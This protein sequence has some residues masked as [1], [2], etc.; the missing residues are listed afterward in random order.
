MDFE[1][2][3]FD[4]DGLLLKT[5]AIAIKAFEEACEDLGHTMKKDVY[6]RCIG[7]NDM[8]AREILTEG[9]GQDFPIDEI[10][11]LW[12]KKYHV[13]AVEQPVPLKK[14]VKTLL[15]LLVKNKIPAAIATSTAYE[16]AIKKLS[17]AGIFGYFNELVSGDMVRESKPHPD[18]YLMAAERIGIKPERCIALEDSE[19]GVRAA[20]AAGMQV[21]QVPDLVEP[22]AEFRQLGH[23]VVAS[24]EEVI[25]YL[26]S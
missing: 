5:E 22:S 2:L 17:N 3:I 4:M 13:R 12:D 19:T 21:F 10:I 6:L 18:I 7:T 25:P 20:L 1:A 24:L 23:T 14:G 8:R 9:F 26:E 16:I 15:D 11:K